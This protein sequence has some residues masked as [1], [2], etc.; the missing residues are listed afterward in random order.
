MKRLLFILVAGIFLSVLP[1]GKADAQI[2]DIIEEVIKDA[3]MAIDLG[4]QK[5]QTQTI[6]LQDAQ[7]VV[8]NAMQQLHL[9]DITN[10]VQQQKD[11]YSEYYQELWQIKNAISAYDKVVSMIDKQAQLVKDYQAAYAAMRRDSHFSSQEISYIGRVY[12]GI[13]N[14]SVENLKQLDLVINALLTQMTDGDRL[15]IIDGAGARIDQNYS[16]LHQFTQQNIL[17]SA[18]RAKDQNDLGQVKLLYGIP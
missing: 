12:S 5:V 2:I 6:Y 10:W 18:Q 8:E 3:I 14:Q 7:K 9:D 13:L 16:D 4:V 17:L 1:A 15:H 11:L